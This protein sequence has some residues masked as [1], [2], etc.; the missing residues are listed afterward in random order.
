V[1]PI[2]KEVIFE[3]LTTEPQAV[4]FYSDKKLVTTQVFISWARLLWYLSIMKVSSFMR[5]SKQGWWALTGVLSWALSELRP[6]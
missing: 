5:C 6:E 2:E 3:K 4:I 1:F